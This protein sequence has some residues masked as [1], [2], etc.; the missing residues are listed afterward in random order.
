[1]EMWVYINTRQ[2]QYAGLIYHRHDASINSGVQFAAN[3]QM[4][5]TPNAIRTNNNTSGYGLLSDT[6]T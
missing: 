6:L 5:N 1:M 4:N 3:W 2:V